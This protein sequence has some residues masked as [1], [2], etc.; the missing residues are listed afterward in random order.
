MD[1]EEAIRRLS[2]ARVGRLATADR[3]SLPHVVPVVFAVAG[4]TIYWAVDE[5]PKSSRELKRIRNI[6]ANPNVE[7]VVDH[8]AE[9]WA[10]LWWVRVSGHARVVGD[11]DEEE[12]AIES[13]AEKYAQYRDDRP[14]GPVVAIDITRVTGWEGAPG[15]GAGDVR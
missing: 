15:G 12:R 1:R 13:L 9:D 7:L 4:E 8:Y 2:A 14:P 6:R 10:H 5:K 3:G 11:E